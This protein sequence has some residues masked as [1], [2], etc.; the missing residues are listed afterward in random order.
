M[1]EE[2]LTLDE[3]ADRL[4]MHRRTIERLV[5]SGRLPAGKFGKQWRVAGSTL[6]RVLRGELVLA[7][8]DDDDAKPEAGK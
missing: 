1:A 2:V 5:R 7:G 6:D 3:V 8:L 4:R